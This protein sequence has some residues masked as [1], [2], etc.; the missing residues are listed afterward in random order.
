MLFTDNHG[1][2]IFTAQL[3]T[4]TV[5]DFK[6]LKCINSQNV[7]V[8]SISCTYT[9]AMFIHLDVKLYMNIYILI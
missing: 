3:V 6:K 2:Q 1:F 7:S 4:A 5:T 9:V 8:V